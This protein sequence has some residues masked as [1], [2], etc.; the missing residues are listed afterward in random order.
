MAPHGG[1]DSATANAMLAMNQYSTKEGQIARQMKLADQL[2]A[3][4]PGMM[5]SRSPINTPNWAGALA[6]AAAGIKANRMDTQADI[7]LEKLGKKKIGGYRQFF[8][9]QTGRKLEPLPEE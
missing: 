3:N 6:G 9:G 5:E 8:E 2:R 1:V 7:D 4:A